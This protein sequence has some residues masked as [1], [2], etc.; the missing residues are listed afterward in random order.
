MSVYM[1]VVETVFVVTSLSYL[2]NDFNILCHCFPVVF[3]VD[4]RI[5]V[6]DFCWTCW[7]FG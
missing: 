2:F 5:F 7:R 3:P 6:T 4:F 1:S